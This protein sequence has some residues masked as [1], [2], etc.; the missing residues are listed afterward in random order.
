MKTKRKP[1]AI[2]KR[3]SPVADALASVIADSACFEIANML[4]G[5]EKHSSPFAVGYADSTTDSLPM[6]LK[7]ADPH[8]TLGITFTDVRL[9]LPTKSI[10]V[11]V[12]KM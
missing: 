8:R 6:L 9:M 2:S 4:F 12:G 1:L 5:S 11:I 3:I 7:I 10:I